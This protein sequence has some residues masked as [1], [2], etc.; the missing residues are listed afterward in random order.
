MYEKQEDTDAQANPFAKKKKDEQNY[1]THENPIQRSGRD[2][3]W[4]MTRNDENN[5]STRGT[6]ALVKAIETG[7][8]P[9]PPSFFAALTSTP[10][11]AALA[12]TPNN[13]GLSMCKCAHKGGLQ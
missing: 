4:M 2:A 10:N 5:E 9:M 7:N 8:V 6:K 11:N 13:V 12:S 1:A 3:V